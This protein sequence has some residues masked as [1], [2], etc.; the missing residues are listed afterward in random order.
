MILV[1]IIFLSG[2]TAP[3][4]AAPSGPHHLTY[5]TEQAPPYNYLENGSVKGFATDLLRKMA[6]AAGEDASAGNF[7]VLPWNE[8]YRR[9]LSE[10]DIVLFSTDRLPEREQQFQWVGPFDTVH[11]V[12][13]AKRGNQIEVKTP[14]D[15]NNYHIGVIRDDAAGTQLQ[16]LGV[17]ESQ[18]VP[19][20]KPSDAIRAL[21]NGTVDLWA[22]EQLSGDYLSSH[23]TGRAGIFVP[24]YSLD[25]TG[26]YYAFSRGTSP[27]IVRSFR[28][29]LEELQKKP[30]DGGMSAYERIR[31]DYYPSAGLSTLHYYTEEYPPLNYRDNNE[32]HGISID[33][34]GAVMSGYGTNVTQNKVILLPWSEG[35]EMAKTGPRTVLFS[36]ARTPDRESLFKWAGPFASSSNA[37]FSVRN[38]TSAYQNSSALKSIRIGIIAN[39][40]SISS[41]KDIG[42][43]ESSLV[44]GHD[45][46]EMVSLLESGAIDAWVTGEMTGKHFIGTFAADPNRYEVIYRFP[47]TDFYYAF[48]PDTPD[49]LVE[50]FQEGLNEV[51]NEK[52]E[53]GVTKYEEIMYRNLGV[54]CARETIQPDQ[55]THLVS[56]TAARLTENATDTIT[57]IN[58]GEDPYWD[59]ANPA[60][61]VYIFDRNVTLVAEAD[62]ISSVGS[63]LKG[64]TD[65]TGNPFRDQMVQRALEKHAGWID[66]IHENPAEQG[67]FKKSA[68]FQLANGSDGNDYIV[69]AGLYSPC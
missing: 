52:N 47:P 55:V 36:V 69:G 44:T 57:R 27:D 50:A 6:N 39:T 49:T 32:L 11:T 34:L 53:T 18:I 30:L 64:T 16:A 68:Y 38:Y 31:A 25:S 56:Y 8:A 41:L 17:H 23:E 1:V 37:V 61:Y 3:A 46:A 21:D 24:V 28:L 5:L 45:G 66:Y 65:V 42:I 26:L 48:S 2:C 33:I 63:N 60:L 58:H 14:D 35:Y 59:K 13:F 43:P 40:S 54:S 7:Q 19:Y 9:S 22:Y 29:A 12:L 51:R 20:Q 15:L 4:P 67:I 62:T 10:P